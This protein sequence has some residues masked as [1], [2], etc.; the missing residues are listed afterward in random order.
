ML[1]TTFPGKPEHGS[2]ESNRTGNAKLHPGNYSDLFTDA[3]NFA[4]VAGHQGNSATGRHYHWRDGF[5]GDHFCWSYI[6]RL[7]ESGAQFRTC[8]CRWE[9]KFALDLFCGAGYWGKFSN[10][11]LEIPEA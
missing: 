4:Y 1:K 9:F 6:R 7:H 8:Y 3:G 11:S 5:T 10:S 2:N